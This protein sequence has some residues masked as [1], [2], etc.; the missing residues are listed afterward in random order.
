MTGE[1]QPRPRSSRGNPDNALDTKDPA[2]HECDAI[3]EIFR[4]LRR[5]GPVVWNPEVDGPG[6]WNVLA[7]DEAN[8]VLRNPAT[9]SSDARNGGVRIWDSRAVKA[10]PGYMMLSMDP[11]GQTAIRQ[12]L[13]G[14]FTPARV[15]AME[16]AMRERADRLIAAIAPDGEA[17][18]VTQVSIPFSVGLATDLLG[19]EEHFGPTL[20]SWLEIMLADDDP[21]I[22]PSE[23]AR[24]ETVRAF[25]AWA[26]RC[27]SGDLKRS[28]DLIDRLRA[29]PI[30]GQPMDAENF[31]L[32]L[33]FLT[34]AFT[35]TTRNALSFTILAIRADPTG[36]EA[37]A[38]D[39]D[40]A[41]FAA[42]EI[43]RWTSPISH[44]R[45]TAMAD[46]VVGGQP[47]RKGDKVVVWFGAASRDP[48]LYRDPDAVD[49]LRFCDRDTPASVAFGAGP[50]FCLGWRYAEREL[51]IML[52]TVLRVLPDIRPA[53]TPVRLRSNFMRG[54]RSLPVQ[55]T[56]RG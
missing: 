2:A 33:F 48:A 52:E 54:L 41:R 28:T 1:L 56:P 44:V 18:Y 11:P 12:A 8:T 50:H 40:L 6:Y 17:D 42:R 13:A 45:R 7:H 51:T 55:F 19:I 38:A 16:T 22:Y 4:E 43:V 25:D 29:A 14:W 39:P 47:I 15:A 5:Q 31:A 10:E 24:D 26:A 36:R 30:N 34:S 21:A 49:L 20:S 35:E 46:T 27:F 37:I 3:W 9:F 53:D 23:E 32:N